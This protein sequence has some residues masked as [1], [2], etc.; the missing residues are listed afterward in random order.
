MRT[1][2]LVIDFNLSY[3]LRLLTTFVEWPPIYISLQISLVYVI[4]TRLSFV[5][6]SLTDYISSAARSHNIANNKSLK[7]VF[8]K[9]CPY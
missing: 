4:L 5:N 6:E 8:F 2:T 3:Q 7:N 1:W 9:E